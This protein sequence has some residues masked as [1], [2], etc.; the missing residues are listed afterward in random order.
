MIQT[1]V[2]ARCSECARVTKVPTYDVQPSY[3]LRAA[4]AG[5]AVA[6]VGGIV[7]GLLLSVHIPFLPWLSAIGVGYLV[8]EAISV[9]A[10]RKRGTGLSV[11]AGLCM[12]LSILVSGYW[13][14]LSV[15]FIFWLLLVGVASYMAISRVR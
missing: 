3:Y 1:P 4:L 12:V 8:G 2:G 15:S 14:S 10:N 6:L 5:G 9:A 13:P 7:W 11:V